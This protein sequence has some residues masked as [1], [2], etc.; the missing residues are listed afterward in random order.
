MKKLINKFWNWLFPV[1]EEPKPE[2]PIYAELYKGKNKKWYFRIK[3][4]GN[5]KILAGTSQGYEN[6]IDMLK[7]LDILITH[8][9][10]IGVTT[11]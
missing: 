5:H 9:N 10:C 8:F 6:K 4:S 1:M 11:K 3:S 7:T 2:C